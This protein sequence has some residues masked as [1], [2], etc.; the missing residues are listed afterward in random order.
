VSKENASETKGGGMA[1]EDE[2]GWG[3]FD[4]T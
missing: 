2:A 4:N 1:Y 3:G